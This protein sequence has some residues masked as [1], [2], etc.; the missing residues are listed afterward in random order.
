MTQSFIALG[1]NLGDSLHILRQAA[2]A[3]EDLAGGG[4]S[5]SRIYRSAPVGPPG[6]EDYLNAVVGMATDL[7][8][9]ALLDT[10]QAIEQ[11][12]GRE[13]TTRW[14]PRTLD[15]D[16]LLYGRLSLSQERLQLPHPRMAERDFVLKPLQ[17]LLG[18]DYRPTGAE[19]IAALLQRCPDNK[20][21]D[22]GL[23]W[24]SDDQLRETITA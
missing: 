7:E 3:L 10:L 18:P 4:L 17:D 8:P 11:A 23:S 6:Q 2:E 13:R 21:R 16:L 15:L 1:S 20:L 9:L 14:G 5:Y 24:Q 12:A 22:S 19:T